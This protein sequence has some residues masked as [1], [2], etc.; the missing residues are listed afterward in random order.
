MI[1]VQ[2]V[3]QARM[4][5]TRTTINLGEISIIIHKDEVIG[6]LT[7]KSSSISTEFQNVVDN[8]KE[9]IG[10]ELSIAAPVDTGDLVSGNMTVDSGNYSFYTDNT[11]PYYPFVVL[12]TSP[13]WIG[14]AVFINK[15]GEWRYIG[16]HPGTVANDFPERALEYGTPEIESRCEEFLNWIVD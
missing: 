6:D 14:S 13:H 2:L 12:G 1:L 11:M 4:S 3:Q 16:M 10:V 7:Q 15:I 5:Q 8:I 9:T